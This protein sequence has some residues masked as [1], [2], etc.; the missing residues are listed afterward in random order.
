MVIYN[1]KEESNVSKAILLEVASREG[2]SLLDIICEY[3]LPSDLTFQILIDV[4]KCS[5]IE[6]RFKEYVIKKAQGIIK[7][8]E[9]CEALA[10]YVE[11]LR[12]INVLSSINS[13]QEIEKSEFIT[14]DVREK[15]NYQ[16]N[17]LT[18]EVTKKERKEAFEILDKIF[19]SLIPRAKGKKEKLQ[20][21]RN[22]LPE[23]HKRIAYLNQEISRKR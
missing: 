1:K 22:F 13:S 2:K 15:I 20:E 18:L 11:E 10:P 14:R 9:D 4:L 19:L 23:G 17:R 16:L 6:P 3:G 21:I 12:S 8:D 7:T 5:Q